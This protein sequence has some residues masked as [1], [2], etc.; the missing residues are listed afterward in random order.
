MRQ[1]REDSE[2]AEIVDEVVSRLIQRGQVPLGTPLE[3]ILEL[4]TAGGS[5]LAKE[6][7][8]DFQLR[9]TSLPPWQRGRAAS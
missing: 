1:M 4:P 7:L 3:S 9:E 6:L 8:L 5:S 2:F